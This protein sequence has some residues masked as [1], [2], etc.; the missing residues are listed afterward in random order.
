M[1]TLS[2]V[3]RGSTYSLSP[4]VFP[5]KT[6]YLATLSVVN[7]QGRP[8]QQVVS[9]PSVCVY[10]CVCMCVC[11]R[12]CMC[13]CVCVFLCM[14]VYMCVCMC[15]CVCMCVCVRVCVC[16]CV[17]VSVRAYAYFCVCVCICVC[18][19]VCVCVYVC[20]CVCS[21]VRLWPYPDSLQSSS[22]HI[23][24]SHIHIFI[25]CPKE[26]DADLRQHLSDLA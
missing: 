25:K 20:V 9:R 8:L 21:H 2:Q 10:I 22:Y 17:C 15:L 14:C 26:S 5:S 3:L 4:S 11:V 16:V 12:V 13:M 7:L 1:T 6:L 24:T 23:N 19:C 18:V